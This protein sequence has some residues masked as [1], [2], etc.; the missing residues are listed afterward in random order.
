MLENITF[1]LI[2]EQVDGKDL[3]SSGKLSLE[4]IL[5]QL[6]SVVSR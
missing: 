5:Q 3:L 2:D 4:L 6:K 1:T